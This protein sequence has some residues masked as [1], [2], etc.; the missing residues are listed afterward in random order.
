MRFRAPEEGN[1]GLEGGGQIHLCMVK[2]SI[3]WLV[4]LLSSTFLKIILLSVVSVFFVALLIWRS[5]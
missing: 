5:R 4:S 2:L 1:E 3:I